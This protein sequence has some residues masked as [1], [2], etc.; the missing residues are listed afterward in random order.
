[1][2]RAQGARAIM[3]FNFE[4][5]Y[6]TPL[7][8]GFRQ[9][10]F[11]STD[12]GGEQP[13][14]DN[15]VLGFGRDPLAPSRDAFNADGSV[16]IPMDVE[17]L[18]LWLKGAFGQP[19]TAAILAAT[20]SLTFSA[21]PVATS[22]ITVAGTVFTFVASGAVGNQINIGANLA[23]TMTAL[24]VVL[25][26]SVIPAVAAA[27]YTATATAINIVFDTLG[28]LGNA[29]TLAAS[30]APVSNATV[31][32][33]TL[34]G[35]ANTHTFQSGGWTLPSISIETQMPEVPRFSM[36]SGVVVDELSWEMKRAG[37][38]QG[39]VKTIAQGETVVAATVAGAL[40]ALAYK[41]FGHFNGAVLRDGVA[42]ANITQARINYMNN[43]ERIDAIRGDGRVE[44]VDPSIAALKGQIVT[45]FS[46]LT[47]FN[48][49]IAGSPCALEFSHTISPSE[50]FVFTAHAVYLPRP[51][52]PIEGPGGVE[53]TFDWQAALA[54]SPAVMA[55]AVL[56]N[57]VAVY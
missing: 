44:G 45:R 54:T 34:T 19:A 49:A 3:A 14:L 52:V 30:T 17:N 18:G 10:P 32:A 37:L 21:Q 41:R 12:L 11:V 43:L 26:A 2:P 38:L 40:T 9:V 47:L 13:L 39:T 42:I 53:A 15:E 6:G 51:R 31:S 4:T 35:G 55:T 48:Q 22:T 16:V 29:F 33:A 57:G 24:A 1:M 8:S 5:I 56:T 23:A 46:D 25:N 7:L 28:H 20:G 36:Y 27:T 50:K